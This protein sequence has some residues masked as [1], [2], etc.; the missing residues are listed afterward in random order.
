M[1][2]RQWKLFTF[3]VEIKTDA[4]NQRF[5]THTHESHMSSR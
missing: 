2:K 1:L 5:N 4:R 3:G